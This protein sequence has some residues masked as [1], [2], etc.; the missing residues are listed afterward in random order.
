MAKPQCPGQD[1]RFWKPGDIFE[2]PC[3][4][5]GQPMEFFKDDL[6]RKCKHCGKYSVNP[7][8]DMACAAWCQHAPECLAQ[9]GREMP[10]KD[11]SES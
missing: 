1:M 2:I 7:K 3:V 4:H 6:R 9:L 11:D 8:N 10:E 5:C